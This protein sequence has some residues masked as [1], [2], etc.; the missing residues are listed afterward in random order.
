MD[1]FVQDGY[2]V[3]RGAFDADIAAA[4]WALIWDSMAGQGIRE[5][6]PATCPPLTELDGMEGEPFTATG[7]SPVLVGACDELIGPGR[8]TCRLPAEGRW[9]CPAQVLAP[10]SDAGSGRPRPGTRWSRPR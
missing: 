2:V 5:D 4:C 10:D 1:A 6:D 3:V 7:S 8:W 9:Q